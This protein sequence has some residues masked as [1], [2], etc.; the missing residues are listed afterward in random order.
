MAGTLQLARGSG[1]TRLASFGDGKSGA[2]SVRSHLFSSELT[3]PDRASGRTVRFDRRQV[4]CGGSALVTLRLLAGSR[5]EQAKASGRKLPVK[6]QVSRRG[7]Y[8]VPFLL[9][10]KGVL[11]TEVMGLFL[12]LWAPIRCCW[13]ADQYFSRFFFNLGQNSRCLIR[14][15]D[16]GWQPSINFMRL[17]CMQL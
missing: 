4:G 14:L 1:S 12:L 3:R 5:T 13:A 11:F 16:R 10:R 2:A 15:F 8:G 7:H 17:D 6:C 9:G